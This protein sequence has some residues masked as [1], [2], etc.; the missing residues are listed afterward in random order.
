MSAR[1]RCHEPMHLPERFW[2]KVAKTETCWLWK[3]ANNGR[4]GRFAVSH[5]D[6]QYAHRVMYE[7]NN[8]SIPNGLQI[9]HLCRNTICVNPSHLEA[10][11]PRENV[12]RSSS[13]ASVRARITQCPS[14]HP[15]DQA[16]THT[17][18]LNQRHCRLCRRN[19]ERIRRARHGS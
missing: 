4:Y 1:S 15:Y 5:S 7:A 6:V 12:L 18:K 14:G 16:N 10:V 17:S 8:G 3:G 13:V 11:T 9:D 2:S 19:R